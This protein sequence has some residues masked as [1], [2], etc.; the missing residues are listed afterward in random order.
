[1]KKKNKFKFIMALLPLIIFICYCF[2]LQHNTSIEFNYF[3]FDNIFKDTLQVNNNDILSNLFSKVFKS[4]FNTD[5]KL[6][7]IY[8]AYLVY[9]EFGFLCYDLIVFLPKTIEKLIH[10]GEEI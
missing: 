9:L 8:F 3:I 5:F 10:R 2:V 7:S 6:I 1:M 4:A